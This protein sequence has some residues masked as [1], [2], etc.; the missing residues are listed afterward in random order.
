MGELPGEVAG[1][2]RRQREREENWTRVFIV[3]S[4]PQEGMGE[5]LASLNNFSLL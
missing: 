2:V 5:A 1:L 4:F 3:V